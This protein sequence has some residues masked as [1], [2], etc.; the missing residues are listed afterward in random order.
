MSLVER[1][2]RTD[3]ILKIFDLTEQAKSF[4]AE[5]SGGQ[6][7]RAVIARSIYALPKIL[8][9]DEPTNNLDEENIIIFIDVVRWLKEKFGSTVVIVSHDVRFRT[10]ADQI[11]RLEGGKTRCE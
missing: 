5:V 8:L 7:Q 4:P 11:I 9:A 2:Q 6:T 1:K 3:R 10:I